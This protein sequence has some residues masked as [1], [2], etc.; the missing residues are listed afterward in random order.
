MIFAWPDLRARH[1]RRMASAREELVR[2][3]TAYQ[4]FSGVRVVAVFDGQGGT[5]TEDTR[6]GGIQVFYSR[7]GQ[8]ADSI[9]ERLV[10][11]YA[12]IHSITV[13]T[14]D[15]AE[16]QTAISFGGETISAEG[17]RDLLAR[18]E[19]DGT[20]EIRRRRSNE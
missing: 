4:D 1:L 17:L 2:R 14:A 16:R 5:I 8:T 19:A 3:L 11:K 13:A 9:I 6:P 18:V 15:R 10:A 12:A 7:S 20:R